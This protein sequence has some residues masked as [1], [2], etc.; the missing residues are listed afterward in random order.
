MK[1]TLA[2]IAS[3]AS[4]RLQVKID[5]PGGG[6]EKEHQS[7]VG[8]IS[9]QSGESVGELGTMF[10]ERISGRLDVETRFRHWYLK[11]GW[12]RILFARYLRESQRVE[13]VFHLSHQ[14]IGRPAR[15]Q[16]CQHVASPHATPSRP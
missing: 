2:T 5:R 1:S 3:A 12:D 16:Q 14:R 11:I 15:E 10:N 6:S 13:D 8:Q 9:P 7:Q 4:W